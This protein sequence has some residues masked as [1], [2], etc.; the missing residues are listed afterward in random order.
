MGLAHVVHFG[1]MTCYMSYDWFWQVAQL[2]HES[3][4]M[5]FILWLAISHEW[6]DAEYEAHRVR[7][8]GR[9]PI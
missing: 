7:V 5:E 2:T 4:L 6:Y 3:Q 9:T 1:H 8:K